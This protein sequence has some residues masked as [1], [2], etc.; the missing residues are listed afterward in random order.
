MSDQ[1]QPT[2]VIGKEGE[3]KKKQNV[4]LRTKFTLDV[5]EEH[6]NQTFVTEFNVPG[7][8]TLAPENP[9]CFWNKLSPG[10]QTVVKEGVLQGWDILMNTPKVVPNLEKVSYQYF[11]APVIV[12]PNF[13]DT[14][15]V[16]QH[17]QMRQV[18]APNCRAPW[19]MAVSIQTPEFVH[20]N[21]QT[22]DRV[23]SNF[24]LPPSVAITLEDDPPSTGF[25]CGNPFP[26]E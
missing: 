17:F 2:D 7:S 3:V 6:T 8:Y 18:V 21:I 22:V 5:G 4:G 20:P 10:E 26:P 13:Q 24:D 14:P 9:G 15:P 11:Q 12:G 16:F 1:C 23:D 25:R 19:N